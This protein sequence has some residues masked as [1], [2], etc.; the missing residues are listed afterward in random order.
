MTIDAIYKHLNENRNFYALHED[1]PLSVELHAPWRFSGTSRSLYYIC[2]GD[3]SVPSLV[4]KDAQ[5]LFAPTFPLVAPPFVS[6]LMPRQG[7][8]N[9]REQAFAWATFVQGPILGDLLREQSRNIP[10][11]LDKNS[12]PAAWRILVKFTQH[13]LD[14]Q[15]EKAWQASMSLEDIFAAL[16]PRITY[17]SSKNMLQNFRKACCSSH[18]PV[19]ISCSWSHGDLWS[20]EIF[21]TSTGFRVIDWEWASPQAPLGADIVDLLVTEAQVSQGYT[22]EDI[23]SALL[24]GTAPLYNTIRDRILRLHSSKTWHVLFHYCLIRSLGRELAQEGPSKKLWERY[25]TLAGMLEEYGVQESG[26]SKAP[27]SG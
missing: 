17:P 4:V 5:P 18:A 13:M 20:K 3:S 10:H 19:M 26:S 12:P 23:W 24:R 25:T 1:V 9:L 21:I 22:H 8:F 6:L 27:T 14:E 2:C 7:I 11:I 15:A 16:E